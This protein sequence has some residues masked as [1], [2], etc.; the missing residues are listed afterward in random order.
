[1][2]SC[3]SCHVKHLNNHT[4]FQNFSLSLS[5]S[6]RRNRFHED[7]D[8]ED[9]DDAGDFGLSGDLDNEEDEHLNPYKAAYLSGY[10]RAEAEAI[11]GRDEG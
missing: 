7:S 4:N 5:F 8:D 11:S 1:M 10:E 2:D 3:K 6:F 9:Q